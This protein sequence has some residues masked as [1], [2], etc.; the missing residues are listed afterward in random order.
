MDEEAPPIN[1]E[2][3]VPEALNAGVYANGF[4]CWYNRTDFT[5]D[6]VV[7][8]P[9]DPAVDADGKPVVRQPV[10]VVSRVKFP[11]SMIFRLMQTLNDSMSN[12]EQQFGSIVHLGE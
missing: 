11:P 8:L 1:V 5:L 4:T 7:H 6:F 12:Y 3:V 10:Q 9:V 2:V